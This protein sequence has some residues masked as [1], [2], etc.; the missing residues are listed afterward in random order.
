MWTF[1]GSTEIFATKE[2]ALVGANQFVVKQTKTAR[3]NL[4]IKVAKLE[5]YYPN[6]AQSEYDGYQVL[7]STEYTLQQ[8]KE[9]IKEFEIVTPEVYE[10]I[11]K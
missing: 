3:N 2:L 7:E 4:A 5:T 1:T 10:L 8:L 9:W 6:D 11:R